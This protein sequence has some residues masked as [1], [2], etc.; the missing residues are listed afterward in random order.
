MVEQQYLERCREGK[1]LKRPLPQ[2]GHVHHKPQELPCVD[3]HSQL[4]LIAK[5][6]QEVLPY[7][8][9]FQITIPGCQRLAHGPP[10][11]LRLQLVQC[12]CSYVFVRTGA[13]GLTLPRFLV[14]NATKC[15]HAASF[16]TD[17]HKSNSWARIGRDGS[18]RE[19]RY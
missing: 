17:I 5:Q 8:P 12:R 7:A 16:V 6:R 1:P 9:E 19:S 14:I 2:P 13:G 3:Q 15:T 11:L 4:L 10:G 18:R